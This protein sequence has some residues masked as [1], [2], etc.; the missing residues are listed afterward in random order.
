MIQAARAPFLLVELADHCRAALV[1]GGQELVGVLGL[2]WKGVR[3]PFPLGSGR[4]VD[5]DVKESRLAG[6]STRCT[7]A[8]DHTVAFLRS[9]QNL[10]A[11]ERLHAFGVED[12]VDRKSTRLNSSHLG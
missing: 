7:P 9:V 10:L 3:E 12:L 11:N 4:G 8:H 2:F 6:Q 1:E 5:K